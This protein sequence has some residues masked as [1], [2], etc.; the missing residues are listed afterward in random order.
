MQVD[1]VPVQMD[2]ASLYALFSW[3]DGPALAAC[4]CVCRHWAAVAASEPLWQRQCA[5]LQPYQ[6]FREDLLEVL[7]GS[8][9]QYFRWCYP[10]VH[11]RVNKLCILDRSSAGEQLQAVVHLHGSYFYCRGVL[12][13]SKTPLPSF[14]PWHSGPTQATAR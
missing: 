11:R 6:L 12:L 9:R 7:G 1:E 10:R 13:Y 14:C 5:L 8:Y 3:L 2:G 4:A